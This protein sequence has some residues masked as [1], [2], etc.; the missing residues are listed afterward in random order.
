MRFASLALLLVI[1]LSV[2]AQ[3][4]PPA[5]PVILS[6]GAV[7]SVE[8]P[9]FA[10][11]PGMEYRLAFEM[12]RPADTPGD[13]NVVLNSVARYLNMHA[14]AGI[15]RDQVSAAVVVHGAAGWE[16][17]NDEAYRAEHGVANDNVQL[18]AELTAAGV[19]VILCGQTAAS[20]G[21]PTDQLADGVQV[22]LSAMTAFLVL[23]EEGYRVNPW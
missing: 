9:D 19:P 7:F 20:R 2:D 8:N 18:I 16:L 11:P 12:A 6:A 1:P 15:P 22:A 5:G 3:D 10:T 13:V 23:Q 4:R 21:I 14:Q 17:L